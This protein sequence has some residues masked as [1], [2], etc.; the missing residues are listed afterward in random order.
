MPQSTLLFLAVALSTSIAFAEIAAR[1]NTCCGVLNNQIHCYGGLV[2]T[3]P[4]EYKADSTLLALDVDLLE[5]NT[6]LDDLQDMWKVVFF[7]PNGVNL[8]PRTDPQC[9]V[10]TEQNRMTINGGYNAVLG[11]KIDTLNPIYHAVRKQWYYNENYHEFLGGDRQIYYGSASYVPGKGA[12][13]Y[14]GYEEYANPYWS[15][16]NTSVNTFFFANN[17][18]RAI[19][20]PSV[21]YFNVKVTLR[22]PYGEKEP[23]GPWKSPPLTADAIDE[24]S[25]KHQSIFDPVTKMLLFMGGEY[26]KSKPP[27]RRPLLRSYSRIKA[28]NTETNVW[29]FVR[30]TGDVPPQGR[31]YSTLTLLP[32]TNRHVLL[33]GGELNYKVLS[34]YCYILDLDSKRWTKQT[35]N[36]PNG[37]ILTRSRHSAVPVGNNTVC[38]MWGIDSN[39]VGTRSILV[40]NTTDPYAITLPMKQT[41]EVTETDVSVDD[42]AGAVGGLALGA[43]V[44]WLCMRSKEKNKMMRN[45][46]RQITVQQE[47][48]KYYEK[49]EAE[50]LNVDWDEI[51][52][53]HIEGPAYTKADIGVNSSSETSTT[54]YNR[55]ETPSVSVAISPDGVE[56]HSN[57]IDSPRPHLVIKPDSGD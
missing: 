40:L 52:N 18:T 41:A 17:K 42:G 1:A 44:I 9:L 50:P 8:I 34:D 45:Q 15:L 23:G 43:L 38:I 7:N 3:S 51:E 48:P 30:L 24:F 31:F 46:E 6:A 2:F 29:S 22:D 49:T 4:T 10:V 39:S 36:A 47:E 16:E 32:S 21:K 14:G 12:A 28:F 26:R 54:F 35:I 27:S 57:I 56:T 37:T 20:Y 33:Y 25:A 53:D 13:F 55:V 11:L 19:G 5:N